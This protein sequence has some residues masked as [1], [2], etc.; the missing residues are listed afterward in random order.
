MKKTL[1]QH[2]VV[3]T[4]QRIYNNH[5]RDNH[6]LAIAT[7]IVITIQIIL[8][9]TINQIILIQLQSVTNITSYIPNHNYQTKPNHANNTL[10]RK[11]SSNLTT[12]KL[13]GLKTSNENSIP[14]KQNVKVSRNNLLHKPKQK[15]QSN[16]MDNSQ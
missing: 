14:C 9:L 16:N 4:I 12:C 1:F 3:Q 5:R 10:H 15:Y 7:T 11:V 8:S 13:Y 6:A 2:Q